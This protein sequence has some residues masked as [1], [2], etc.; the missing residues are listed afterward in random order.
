MSL[1]ETSFER[2]K[3]TSKLMFPTLK[4]MCEQLDT[5]LGFN[6]EVKYPQ[7]IEDHIDKNEVG[8]LFK[9]LNRNEYADII[10]KELYTCLKNDNQ[11]CVILTTFDP[12]LCSM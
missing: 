8:D 1:N 12:L 2:E 9:W 7:D 5:K 6:V 10:I 11:R 3:F 4:E